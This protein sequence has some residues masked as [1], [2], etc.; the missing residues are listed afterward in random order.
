MTIAR[1]SILGLFAVGAATALTGCGGGGS[2]SIPTR[3]MWVLNLNSEFPSADVAF[4]PDPVSS[5]LP[6]QALTPRI[7][8]EFG[9]YSVGLRDRASGRTLYFDGF[10]V[11]DYSPSIEVFYR[12][13]TSARLGAS[14]AGIVNYFESPEALV[15][16]LDDG[17]GSVQTTVLSFEDSAPQASLSANC[18]LT[19]RRA[20]DGVLVYDSG[21]RQRT[22]A[23]LLFPSDPLIGFVG[24]LGLNYS[25]S[26]AGAVSWPNI[27]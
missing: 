6:F 22:G 5:A 17:A 25:G 3:F 11:D 20:N 13:G 23:I 1:R 9:V 18:R 24:A 7:E 21:L 15:V 8:V 14:P 26:S 4:G 12:H 19:V 2:D 10:V 27:L 16:E